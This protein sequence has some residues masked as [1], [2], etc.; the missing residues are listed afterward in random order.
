MG[1]NRRASL[2]QGSASSWLDL[3]SFLPPQFDNSEANSIWR[4]GDF[5]YVAGT[6]W[7]SE[8]GAF[9]EAVMWVHQIPA[10]S[11]AMLVALSSMLGFGARRR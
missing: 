11:T 4:E 6:A 2:W 10:P 3:G 1:S 7:G 9:G 5:L 8:T